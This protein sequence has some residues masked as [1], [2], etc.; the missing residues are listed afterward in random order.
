MPQNASPW[1]NQLERIRP[2]AEFSGHKDTDIAIVGGGIAGIATAYYILKNTNFNVTL[3][4]AYKIAHGAS[5]HNGGFLASYF[6]RSFTSLVE[7]FGLDLAANAQREMDSS[8]SLLDDMFTDAKLST[9]M[10]QFTGLAG[11]SS[12]EDTL[13]HLRSHVLKT[14]AGLFPPKILISDEAPGVNDIPA[15]FEAHYTIL[16]KKNLLELLE[17][18]DEKYI[19]ALQSRKG[20]MNSAMLCEEITG[21]LLTTYPDR[22]TLA[23]KTKVRRLVLKDNHAVL[24]IDKSSYVSAKKVILCTNGFENISIVNTMGAELDKKFHHLVR[25]I[26]GYMA[27]YTEERNKPPTEISYL[28]PRNKDS[29]DVFTEPPYFYLTRRPYDDKG[30]SG[31]NLVCIGG[32]EVLMDDTN[33]YHYDHEFP[34]E[35]KEEI[36]AFLRTTYKHTRQDD[37]EYKFLWHGLMGFTPNG[38]RL[39]GPE[40]VNP[41]LHYNL[42]CNGVGLMPSIYGGF[43]I[44]Q[45]LSGVK[46]PKSIF[47]PRNVVTDRKYK[48]KNPRDIVTPNKK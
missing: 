1:L 23:E 45:I 42:G 19:S 24:D 44:S 2:I 38:V 22:F 29:N 39:I 37:T 13:A 48:T 35:A 43:K 11:C 8:W 31:K 16:P 25:G 30:E 41:I 6:E 12:M 7:E 3:I 15:E 34:K 20:C 14:Q 28:P 21:Y 10:W 32:P 27:G 17:T 40:P 4:E 5:G 26:V 46:L 36:N 47:D 33:N 18:I 9:P